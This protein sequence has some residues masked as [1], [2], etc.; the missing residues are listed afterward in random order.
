MNIQYIYHNTALSFHIIKVVFKITIKKTAP[1]LL[2]CQLN[3]LQCLFV[4]EQVYNDLYR[5]KRSLS[6]HK[7]DEC[8]KKLHIL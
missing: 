5:T 8:P 7:M 4:Q 3:V 2:T 6:Q 1:V